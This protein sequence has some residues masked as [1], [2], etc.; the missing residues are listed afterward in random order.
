M[1]LELVHRCHLRNQNDGVVGGNL[2]IKGRYD[3]NKIRPFAKSDALI[4][5]SDLIIAH[6]SCKSQIFMIVHP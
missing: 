4:F 6:R 1:A 3:Y 2:Q 5:A